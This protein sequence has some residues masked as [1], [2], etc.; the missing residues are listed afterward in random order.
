MSRSESHTTQMMH[1]THTHTH[2]HS[3]A[4]TPNLFIEIDDYASRTNCL[5]ANLEF[6]NAVFP[7]RVG[8]YLDVPRKFNLIS[9]GII[10]QVSKTEKK[11][12]E[13]KITQSMTWAFF[14]KIFNL[15]EFQ[16][17]EG[18]TRRNLRCFRFFFI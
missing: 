6:S 8:V 2:T 17:V 18:Q 5:M 12:W 1:T 4:R 9:F 3:Q 11:E 16:R 15:Y 14:S 10:F 7:S 13:K